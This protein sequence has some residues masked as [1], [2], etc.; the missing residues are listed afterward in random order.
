MLQTEPPSVFGLRA[1]SA[2]KVA[3]AV[4]QGLGTFISQSRADLVDVV[5]LILSSARGWRRVKD[6]GLGNFFKPAPE[7]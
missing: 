3:N 6:D 5:G 2:A 7:K 1:I 4:V